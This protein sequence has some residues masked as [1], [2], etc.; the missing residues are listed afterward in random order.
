MKRVIAV[1][2]DEVDLREGRVFVNGKELDDKWAGTETLESQGAIVYPY[3]VR[4]GRLFVLGDNRKVSMDSRT[5]GEVSRRQV[6]GRLILHMG[7][8][9]VKR[10]PR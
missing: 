8:W 3:K 7:R 9:Y 4:E 1:G 5:F 2:G 10:V 6:R